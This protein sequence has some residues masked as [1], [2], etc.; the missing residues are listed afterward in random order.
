MIECMVSV[1]R[2]RDVSYTDDR[3]MHRSHESKLISGPKTIIKI[4]Q[5]TLSYERLSHGDVI[6]QRTQKN[7]S[8]RNK[9]LRNTVFQLFL[10][11]FVNFACNCKFNTYLMTWLQMRY[12]YIISGAH[13]NIKNIDMNL[14]ALRPCNG[15]GA[16]VRCDKSLH[17]NG[18]GK[19]TDAINRRAAANRSFFSNDGSQ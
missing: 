13:D 15:R 19:G 9:N 14:Q 18:I 6:D 17:K 1:R 5:E 2:T 3:T 12:N 10:L 7:R 4:L 11:T 8:W 16:R